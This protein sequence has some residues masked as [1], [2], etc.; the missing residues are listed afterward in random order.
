VPLLSAKDHSALFEEGG[1][2]RVSHTHREGSGFS[3]VNYIFHWFKR[4]GKKKEKA[5]YEVRK[6]YIHVYKVMVVLF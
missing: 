2:A 1:G 5:D 3:W 6:I 4:N